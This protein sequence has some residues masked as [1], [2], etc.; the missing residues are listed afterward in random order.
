MRILGAYLLLVLG[1]NDSPSATDI[2]S[3]LDEVGAKA[4][5]EQIEKVV[6][7]LNGKDINEL[8]SQGFEKIKSVP[9]LGSG[10]PTAGGA[11][12]GESINLVP[13]S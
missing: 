11:A 6:K 7:E 3:L 2:T 1:G 4:E 12:A 5:Q 13:P 8:I 9:A 10:A